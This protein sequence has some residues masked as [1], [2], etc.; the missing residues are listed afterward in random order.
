MLGKQSIHFEKKPYIIASASIV[1][2]KEAE[3]PMGK[4]FDKVGYD[5]SFGA[6]NWEEAESRLQ[7]EALEIAI[8]KAGLTKQDVQMVFAGDLLGQSIASS[9]GLAGYQL[10]HVGLYGACSTCGLSLTMGAAMVSAG[11]AERVAC[12]TSSH[13]ASAEKE[14]RFPLSYGNQRPK[15]ATWT[16]TGSGAF[17]LSAKPEK[18]TRA[19]VEGVTVGKIMDYGVK[20]SMNMGACMAPAAADTIKQNLEDFGRV[21]QDYDKI[22]TG[23]LGMVGQKL[24]FDLLSEQGIDIS[25]QHMDCGIEIYE[26]EKQ[27]TDAGGS[28]CGCSAVV[29][30]AYILKKLEEGVWKRVL[31]VPTGAL[32]SKTSYNE[33]QT[34]PG[35]AH[36]VVL[37][38]W[39]G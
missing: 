20:D 2:S 33:G 5:D 7:K 38:H 13:F 22:I 10:P 14:F 8:S 23:D 18:G 1:G 26:N 34:I 24:L 4:L 35:I 3:G 30:S 37:E 32:L 11:F 39:Q 28:G 15:S 27:H 19:M 6:Q 29:L 12:I 21:P 17:L 36:G 25:R 31:F 16:V 9:F